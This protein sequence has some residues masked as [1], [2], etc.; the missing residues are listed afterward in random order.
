MTFHEDRKEI[1]SAGRFKPTKHLPSSW[2]DLFHYLQ[3]SMQF[4]IPISDAVAAWM[5]ENGIQSAPF[6]RLLR[7]CTQG[8]TI[9]DFIIENPRLVPEEVWRLFKAAGPKADLQVV[10]AEAEEMLGQKLE[11]SRMI[12]SA[13]I[14]PFATS[15]VAVLAASILLWKVIPT[16]SSLFLSAGARLPAS[17]RVMIA[18]SNGIV[19]YGLILLIILF[20][21]GFF[22]QKLLKSNALV[23]RTMAHVPFLGKKLIQEES[24]RLLRILTLI[25]KEGALDY[26]AL[27]RATDYLALPHCRGEW[28]RF[29]DALHRG[30]PWEE[31]LTHLAF[32]SPDILYVLRTLSG[33]EHPWHLLRITYGLYQEK[34][35]RTQRFTARLLEPLLVL[36]VG[37]IVGGLVLAMYAPIF[38]IS[39]LVP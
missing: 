26:E 32:L 15:L 30:E 36:V 17:T 33:K 19:E 5:T 24:L 4:S 37:L 11:F 25:C 28:K 14:H 29:L 8:G 38:E 16:F 35:Q 12:E 6:H 21:S 3:I 1:L 22:L 20:F 27:E 7:H 2:K 9:T 10:L 31:A 39:R 13:L 23:T 18:A 34:A